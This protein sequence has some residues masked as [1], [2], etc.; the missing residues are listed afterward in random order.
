MADSSMQEWYE[1]LYKD[2]ESSQTYSKY[3][4]LAFGA[5][6]SQQGF[7]NQVEVKFILDLL[8]IKPSDKVLDLGCGSG[9]LDGYIHETT[10]ASVDGI[11]YSESAIEVA[12]NIHQKIGTP[13]KFSCADMDSLSIGC[14]SY[15]VILALD[16]LFFSSDMS[17]Q[18]KK[19]SNWLRPDGRFA[20]AYSEIR[21][22]Q[23]I[24]VSI[25]D[26]DNTEVAT[27]FQ[28]AG[29]PYTAHD[30]TQNLYKHMLLKYDT[31]Q[32][33]KGDFI[34]EGNEYLYDYIVR[35]SYTPELS[36]TDF[37][38]FQRRYIYVHEK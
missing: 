7:S 20:A 31:A 15:D 27:A 21:F 1:K 37:R 29:I 12:K 25:L 30:V 19:I 22:D 13:L 11:D 17:G 32:A 33:L 36:F 16:S 9:K 18:I 34:Y 6:L 14:D 26:A 35:E 2:V 3:C 5:D 4:E 24:P 28:S 23:D 38:D 8:K 10:G